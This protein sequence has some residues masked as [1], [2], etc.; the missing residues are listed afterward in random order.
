VLDLIAAG[1]V[2]VALVGAGLG[3]PA[4]ILGALGLAAIT[5]I[6]GFFAAPLQREVEHRPP[7]PLRETVAYRW[8]RVVQRRPWTVALAS[9]AALL[10]L[11]IPVL[12]LRLGFSDE[13]NFAQETTT[14]QAYDLI[15]EGFGEGSTGPIYLV[16]T[17]DD[18][19]QFGSMVAL[20]EAVAAD[21]DVESVLGPEPN[22]AQDPTAV[23]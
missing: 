17:V 5:I 23:R 8:S 14:K 4:I 15:V 2:A 12:D 6:V 16:A 7:K 18:P 21:V 10:V 1:L 22:D 11:A 13:S 20:G 19:D 3:S 9:S